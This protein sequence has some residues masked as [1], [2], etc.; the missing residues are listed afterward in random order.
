MSCLLKYQK[1]VRIL[2]RHKTRTFLGFP[3][4]ILHSR[5]SSMYKPPNNITKSKKQYEELVRLL[6][7]HIKTLKQK[8]ICVNDRNSNIVNGS[9]VE[10]FIESNHEMNAEI[11]PLCDNA[12]DNSVFPHSDD[13]VSDI[14]PA[15]FDLEVLMPPIGNL[16][17]DNSYQTFRENLHVDNDYIEATNTKIP[18][19]EIDPDVINTAL[20]EELEIEDVKLINEGKKKKKKLKLSKEDEE[21]LTKRK[22]ELNI[23]EKEKML[24]SDLES[25]IEVCI[26]SKLIGKAHYTLKYYFLRGLSSDKYPKVRD[27]RVFDLLLSGWALKGNLYKFKQ[28]LELMKEGNIKPSLQTYASYLECLSRQKI[29]KI[30][31]VEKVLQTI[32]DNGYKVDDIF[33]HCKFKK[34]QKEKITEVIKKVNSSFE[35]KPPV[36]VREYL[37][38]LLKNLNN[39]EKL[40]KYSP[41]A[42]HTANE[43]KSFM[44]RQFQSE[45][46]GNVKV[47]SVNKNEFID[48][49]TLNARNKLKEIE[50]KWKEEITKTF[51]KNRKM[52]QVHLLR[53]RGVILYPYLTVLDTDVYVGLIME[54]IRNLMALSESFS[55]SLSYLHND[56]G[57]KVMKRYIAWYK[58]H[59]GIADKLMKLYE[60]YLEYYTDPELTTLYSP[61]EYWE[62]L[63]AKHF[64]GPCIDV[65]HGVWPYHVL[66]GVGKFLY[67]ILLNSTKINVN[68][69][70]TKSPKQMRSAFHCV[71]RNF[72]L[73]AR[74]NIKPDPIITKLYKDAANEELHFET[75]L[76][77]MCSPPLPWTSSQ[78]VGFLLLESSLIRLPL[79][80][81]Y[82]HANIKNTP[83]Q[84]LYPS[85]DSLNILSL[86]PWIVNK[87]MLELAIEIFNNGGSSELDIPSYPSELSTL[88]LEG[89]TKSK[90]IKLKQERAEMYS[91]WCDALYKLSIANHFKDEVFWFPHNMDFRGRVYPTPPHF[92]HLG[93]DMTRSILLFAQGKP[94]GEK[95]LDWLKIHL[96][97]LT[98]FKKREPVSKR[99]Q[100]ANEIIDEILDSADNPLTGNKWWMK[101][102]KPWQTLA[103]CKEV[104]YALRSPDYKKYI[105]H[106]PIHQDG[107]CNGLQHYAA[108]GR[109][110]HG[111]EQVNLYPF[112]KPQDV[113]TGVATLVEKERAKDAENDVKI[114]QILEGFIERKV[115]KQTVMTVV[116][117]VTRYGAR[118]QI[119]KQLKDL[120][121]FPQD[122]AN[123]AA[124]YLVQKTFFSLRE[125]FTATREIQ[126]WFTDCARNISQLRAEP[127]QWV[128]PLGL[129]IIQPYHKSTTHTCLPNCKSSKSTYTM[130]NNIFAPPNVLKQKNA[131]PPNFIHSLDSSHM[132]LTSLFCRKEGITFVSVHD[133]F[134]THPCDVEIMNRICREQ[135]VA[136]HNEPILENLSD[137]FYKHYGYHEEEKIKSNSTLNLSKKHINKLLRDIPKKGSFKLENVLNSVYFFS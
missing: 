93:G 20:R 129:P 116:Y 12:Q 88:N 109:D 26:Y 72:G 80:A 23:L 98:G 22:L 32:N 126:D 110:Q 31:D 104:S 91:L 87:P 97:N 127:V 60:Q 1:Y 79:S 71:L 68:M 4:Q 46:N 54:E 49:K 2:Q 128:T 131:F 133:C 122:Y 7:T 18:I 29:I 74:H 38:D 52:L 106:I 123:Q 84:Q 120:K 15:S 69:F 8:E 73:H 55:P 48:K 82:Q 77:P 112:D 56:L 41:S 14:D 19:D 28:L 124:T 43:L 94:L 37:C 13:T 113:Y 33:V 67:D 50:E 85:F 134:W 114:A 75:N 121:E 42:G 66:L 70:K 27:I 96:I 30:S 111:A 83:V 10:E 64:M 35:P 101:S 86:C 39:N 21:K 9:Y 5:T 58:Q 78:L 108:L 105:S 89:M 45:V 117:G 24:L 11:N 103:C 16:G 51:I 107:S 59:N 47:I 61:R 132:M 62:I 90:K 99:L 17:E 118:L 92:N 100:Y 130:K 125:M 115:I 34:D 6:E 3:A 44:L 119:L 81:S 40:T 136:L 102:D 63:K 135:F 137:Y 76:L 57:L 53:Y 65:Q 95:G 36:Y 25:F